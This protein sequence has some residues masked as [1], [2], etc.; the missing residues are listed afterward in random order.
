MFQPIT[1]ADADEVQQL[2]E[3]CAEFFVM[4]DGAPPK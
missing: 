1:L 4:S 2:L 3:R